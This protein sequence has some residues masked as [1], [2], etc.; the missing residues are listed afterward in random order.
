MKKIRWL[1]ITGLFL[2]ISSGNLLAAEIL[3]PVDYPTIQ[4]AINAAQAGDVVMVAAG[5]YPENIVMKEGVTLKG[6]YSSDFSARDISLYVTVNRKVLR[7]EN[8]V[9]STEYRVLSTEY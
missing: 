1:F 4:D 2:L 6:G 8:R 3:V 9:L 5:T 7:S